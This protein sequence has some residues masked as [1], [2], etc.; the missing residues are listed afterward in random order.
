MKQYCLLIN[1]WVPTQDGWY[2]SG[3]LVGEY[4]VHH[5]AGCVPKCF[6]PH[7]SSP[8]VYTNRHCYFRDD[9]IN[10]GNSGSRLD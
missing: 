10:L 4:L 5:T 8:N 9:E 6:N 1:K 3:L 7:S 2:A